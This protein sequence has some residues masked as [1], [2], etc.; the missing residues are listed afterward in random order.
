M[1]KKQNK[2][3]TREFIDKR[4]SVLDKYYDLLEQDSYCDEDVLALIKKDPDFY[5]TYLY[6][7]NIYR[8]EDK[9]EKKARKLE[10]AAFHRA[11]ACIKDKNGNWPDKLRWGFLENRHIIRALNAGADNLWK[12]NKTEK[13][14]DVYRKLFHSNPND[15]IGARY[16]IIALRMGLA[17]DEYMRQV[18]PQP[19]VPADHIDAWFRK[20]APKFPEE[21]EGWKQYC[22][23]ELDLNEKDLM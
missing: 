12:D 6:L 22:K 11:L 14:L 9:N 8:D 23:T 2:N 3:K 1:K 18:W 7:A 20:N 16:A 21:L 17:Y 5:D 4:R 15:N 19:T 13:A 10:D